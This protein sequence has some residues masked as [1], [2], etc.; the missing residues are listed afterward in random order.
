MAYFVGH[1]ALYVAFSC[2]SIHT[3][4]FVVIKKKKFLWNYSAH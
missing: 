2:I 3:S 4:Q 1:I